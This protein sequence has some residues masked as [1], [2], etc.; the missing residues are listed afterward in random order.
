MKLT[1][2]AQTLIRILDEFQRQLSGEYE[3]RAEA[4]ARLAS[5]QTPAGYRM[6]SLTRI[7]WQTGT[8]TSTYGA[9]GL[10]ILVLMTLVAIVLALAIPPTRG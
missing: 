8:A 6:S 9:L 1:R 3:R 7:A 4:I 5:T 2:P 10:G